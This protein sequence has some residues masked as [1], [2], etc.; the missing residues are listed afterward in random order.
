MMLSYR[1]RPPKRRT[2]SG[3][4][5]WSLVVVEAEAEEARGCAGWSCEGWGRRAV[6][7][8]E[9]FR[10]LLTQMEKYLGD[11]LRGSSE[12]ERRMPCAISSDECVE[13]GRWENREKESQFEIASRQKFD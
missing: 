4:P 8:R 1:I 9:C 3:K 12:G 10:A 2:R 11:V 5:P 6:V 7:E 13:L